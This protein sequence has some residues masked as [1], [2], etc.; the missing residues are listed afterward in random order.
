MPGRISG[1]AC[2]RSINPADVMQNTRD[3]QQRAREHERRLDQI[4]PDD[5]LDPAQRG[6]ET[7][8]A[9]ERGDGDDVD[10]Q[11]RAPAEKPAPAGRR[12]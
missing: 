2:V 5:G 10:R 7:G 11:A 4:G 1:T 12:F 9:R 3:G 8:E 6:V